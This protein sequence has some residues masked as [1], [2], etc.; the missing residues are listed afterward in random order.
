[1]TGA[2]T[3]IPKK[4]VLLGAGHAHVRVLRDFGIRP[5]PNAGLTLITKHAKTPYSGMLPGLIAGLYA[6]DETHIDT[7][8][9]CT[10]A[11]AE[12]CLS[13]AIGVDLARKAVLCRDRPPVPFDILSIDIGSTPNTA[14]VPSARATVIPVKPIDGFLPRFEAARQ[15]ILKAGGRSRVCVVGG[16]AGG[17]ELLLSLERRLRR[18]CKEAGFDP[19]ALAF[20]LC[21]ADET[22]LSAFPQKLRRRVTTLLKRR[23]VAI[24]SGTQIMRADEAH[25][26]FESGD[27]L[28]CDEVF[29]ATSAA[30]AP[31]LA[32]T[33]LEL[34]GAGFIK[35]NET[36]KS[37]TRRDVFA[38]GDVAAFG[39][40]DLPKSGV[41][42]VRQGEVLAENIRRALQN[43]PLKAYKPQRHVLSL[44]STGE[45]YAIGTR[46][47]IVFEGRAI[48][49][50]KDFIDRRFMREFSEL[51]VN[52]DAAGARSS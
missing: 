31:W 23:G 43:R 39:P 46:N 49:Y 30:A 7:R 50:L 13:E 14:D 47:G 28:E 12:L 51:P 17:V 27:Q 4:V 21:T 45:R 37:E 32:R 52:K 44:M 5:F 26:H 41:F 8:P 24:I 18:D 29:W 3:S 10:F 19:E 40:R 15:R 6:F 9:L 33:G 38:A 42:A 34:D 36:L 22:I 35:V 2:M 48:W 1:M 20:S 16:G 11:N 25:L